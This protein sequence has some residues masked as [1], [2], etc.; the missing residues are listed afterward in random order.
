MPLTLI[1]FGEPAILST[2]HQQPSAVIFPLS[3]IQISLL[4]TF[5][6]YHSIYSPSLSHTL[7]ATCD[8]HTVDQLE[9]K[10]LHSPFTPDDVCT[11]AYRHTLAHTRTCEMCT[12]TNHQLPV[13]NED[14]T[15][16]GR[17]V[18]SAVPLNPAIG[19]NVDGHSVMEKDMH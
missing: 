18:P 11:H 10:S 14:I 1:V 19:S 12:G 17:R 7:I 2:D 9:L 3:S 5:T 15:T 13:L 16:P 6:T 8:I 4:L